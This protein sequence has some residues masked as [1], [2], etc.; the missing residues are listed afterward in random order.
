MSTMCT[1]PS[2]AT[3]FGWYTFLIV[4]ERES[5]MGHVQLCCHVLVNLKKRQ[6]HQTL[7]S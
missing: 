2:G 3:Q 4:H 5:G 7:T 6:D 1:I